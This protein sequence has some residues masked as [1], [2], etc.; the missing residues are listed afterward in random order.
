M[1]VD[2][3]S[4]PVVVVI[5]LQDIVALTMLFSTINLVLVVTMNSVE[6]GKKKR[7]IRRKRIFRYREPSA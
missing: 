4:L 6:R 1:A 7:R 2:T 5:R 3:P